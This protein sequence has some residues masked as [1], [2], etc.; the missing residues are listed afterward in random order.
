MAA[1]IGGAVALARLVPLGSVDPFKA[2]V[3]AGEAEGV[4]VYDHRQARNRLSASREREREGKDESEGYEDPVHWAE[5][6]SPPVRGKRITVAI[7]A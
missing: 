3:C 4:T 6:T 7:G 5:T 2:N 1:L